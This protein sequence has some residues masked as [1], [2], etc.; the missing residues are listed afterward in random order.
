[1]KKTHKSPWSVTVHA[2]SRKGWPRTVEKEGLGDSGG[3]VK[4]WHRHAGVGSGGGRTSGR[5]ST[6]RIQG[7]DDGGRSQDGDRRS[8]GGSDGGRSQ[9]EDRRDLEQEKPGGTK[10][11]A[12]KVEGGAMVEERLTTPRGRLMAAEQVEPEAET[13]SRWA[14]AT[15]RIRRAK[16]E[17]MAPA[18]EAEAGIRKATVEPEWQRPKVEPEGRR[19]LTEPEGRGVE[20]RGGRW[21]TTDQGGAGGTREPG[22][23]GGLTGH[24]REE[25]REDRW[26]QSL[27]PHSEVIMG[28]AL[29]SEW[30]WCGRLRCPQ[31]ANSVKRA[32]AVVRVV[33]VIGQEHKVLVVVL[34]RAVALLQQEDED[35]R[36]VHNGEKILPKTKN[37]RGG[38]CCY[39]LSR[40]CLLSRFH[41]ERTRTKMKMKVKDFNIIH[42][43]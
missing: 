8:Q 12:M 18:T 3:M 42:T 27:A 39:T 2:P 31:S 9:G 35:S 28:W 1:M 33:R 14:R 13:E 25:G 43:R 4:G 22:G 6:N 19:S 11:A 32:E 10:A 34:E 7:G 21:S 40:S 20:S 41:V 36:I 24:G 5:R 37:K 17:Q 23:A 29:G 16:A 38:T 15:P 30:G 26:A